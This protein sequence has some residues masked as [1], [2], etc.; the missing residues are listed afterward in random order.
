M[1]GKTTDRI[2]IQTAVLAVLLLSMVASGFSRA[3]LHSHQ[4]AFPGHTHEVSSHHHHEHDSEADL[5]AI[6]DAGPG[7]SGNTDSSHVHE[8]CAPALSI[9]PGTTFSIPAFPNTS[10]NP[11]M[12]NQRPPDKASP[13]LYRPPIA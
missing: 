5:R 8:L 1:A 13:P 2:G 9:M 11:A 6:P 10:I 4:D 3:E 7:Q 12:Q